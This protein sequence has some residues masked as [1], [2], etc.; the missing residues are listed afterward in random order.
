MSHLFSCCQKPEPVMVYYPYYVGY[1]PYFMPACCSACSMPYNQCTCGGKT[2]VLIPEELAVDTTTTPKETFIGGSEDVNLTLE[3]MSDG[4]TPATRNVTL[5]INS[6]G[7][8]TVWTETNIADGY[9]IKN[10]FASIPPGA[11]VELAVTDCKARLRWC[12]TVCC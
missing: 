11:T 12:E 4:G 9:H 1:N 5:T 3:Y 8:T 2:S 10:E 7:S 6:A